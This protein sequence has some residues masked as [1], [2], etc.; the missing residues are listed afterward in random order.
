MCYSEPY[1]F[2]NIIE[3]ERQLD[4]KAKCRAYIAQ[5]RFKDGIQ[6]PHCNSN[7]K[8]SLI[9]TKDVIKCSKCRET[10]PPTYATIFEDS[11]MDIRTWFKAMIY[12]LHGTSSNKIHQF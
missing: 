3:L 9:T 1:H 5:I 12:F 4:T 6:C 2:K 10:F 11:N 8:F 7:G